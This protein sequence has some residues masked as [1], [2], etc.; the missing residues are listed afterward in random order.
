MLVFVRI[1][2]VI[3]LLSAIALGQA[4]SPSYQAIYEGNVRFE[5]CYALEENP[6]ASMPDKSSCWRDWSEHYTFGQ[7]RDRVQYAISRYVALS[8][9][10]NAPT[11]EAMMMAAPGETPR[12]TSINAPAPTNPFAPPPKVLD[13]GGDEKK[14]ATSIRLGGLGDP[15]PY[16]DAGVPAPV[17]QSVVLPAQSCGDTCGGD[18]KTC[19]SSCDGDA[20]ASPKCKACEPKYRACM[21]GC[22]K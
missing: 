20:G 12:T 22:Y 15:V 6:G 8:R 18:F 5:H 16:I 13:N 10:G 21:R 3:G 4:C 17:V 11:D 1:V 19:R 14:A 7:T 9:I 2:A